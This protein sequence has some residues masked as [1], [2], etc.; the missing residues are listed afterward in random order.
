M[1]ALTTSDVD[2]AVPTT[3]TA[4]VSRSQVNSVL[5]GLVTGDTAAGAKTSGVAYQRQTSIT[6]A[7]G[8]AS[9]ALFVA[10][11]GEAVYTDAR[12]LPT[13]A[14]LIG[15]MGKAILNATGRTIGLAIGTEGTIEVA[16]GTT[17]TLAAPGVFTL[18]ANAGTITEFV[19][20]MSQ[21]TAN[22]GTVST[23]VGLRS[24]VPNNSGT[25]GSIVGLDVPDMGALTGVTG[26]RWA[27]R[28]KDQKSIIES[29]GSII[30]TSRQ[31]PATMASGGTSVLERGKTFVLL[32][33]AA[34]LASHTLSYPTDALDGQKLTFLCY[35]FGITAL[36]HT[37]GGASFFEAPAS[38]AKGQTFTMQ[39]MDGYGGW[40]KVAS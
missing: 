24:Y 1:A 34:Q 32:A 31:G 39:K 18:N 30:D 21:I 38:L 20:V 12:D 14:H 26:N 5:K 11:Y 19:G 25:I 29:A 28:N 33:P 9:T 37:G 10:N 15:A 16:A 6:V 22:A 40:V 36:S 35:G 2:A 4:Q 13:P 8:V 23:F 3:G 17:A 27:V 7:P